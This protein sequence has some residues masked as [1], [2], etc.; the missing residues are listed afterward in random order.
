VALS[1]DALYAC[2]RLISD[3]VASASWGEWRGLTR[4]PDSRLA[5]RPMQRLTRRHWTW[6]VTSTMALYNI[7]PLRLMG[8]TDD[9][10][11]PWSLVPLNP[12]LLTKDP[13]SRVYRYG[14]EIIAPDDLRFIQRATFPSVTPAVA[15]ILS[16][17]RQQIEAAASAALYAG[18]WWE[19]GGAPLVVLTTDQDLTKQQG[20]DIAERWLERRKKGPAYP[21]V[22]GK[23]AKAQAFGA[24]LGTEEAAQAADRLIASIARY[25]GVPPAYVNAPSY[26]GS[27]TYQN[28]EQAGLD[29]VRYTLNGYSQPIGDTLS[30][31]L[32][33]DYLVGRSIRL[34]LSA[35]TRGE[36]AA[37]YAAWASAISAGWLTKDEV[38]QAEGYPPLEQAAA[39][40][41]AVDEAAQEAAGAFA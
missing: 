7:C 6:L 27:L 35:L 18:S 34:D 33:G 9:E 13:G 12:A 3:G 31:L 26:A 4:L 1:V 28:V 2:V 36:Q 38:R 22:M 40:G 10:G 25:M 32:P 16:L 30:D 24:N 29:L 8:G 19:S 11:V 23:G 17:A 39:V 5:R 37:R 15:A 14:D 41:P 21:A 20:E